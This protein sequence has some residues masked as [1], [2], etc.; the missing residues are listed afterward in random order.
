MA[1]GPKVH[2]DVK[3]EKQ[4]TGTGA[5]RRQIPL[6]KPKWEI[7]EITNRQYTMKTNG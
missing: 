5:N 2:I 3:R 1:S 4:R 7:T 6:S